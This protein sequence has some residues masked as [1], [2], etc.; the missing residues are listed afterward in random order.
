ML[1]PTDLAANDYFGQSVAI[2]GNW[3]IVGA[4]DADASGLPDT[5]AAY[6]FQLTDDKWVQKHKL[7][8]ADVGRDDRFG[9]SVAIS[10]NQTIVGAYCCDAAGFP[11]AGA[12]YIFEAVV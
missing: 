1:L 6:V 3:A 4:H 12:A 7:Q 2:S 11:D 8:P 10:G 9:W 5:G